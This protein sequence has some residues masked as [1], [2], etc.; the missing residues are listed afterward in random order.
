MFFFVD[1]WGPIQVKKRGGK[2]Y[3]ST[4]H[5]TTIPRKQKPKGTVTLIGALSAT[6]N[7]MA[8]LFEP[9]KDTRSIVNLLE[10]LHNQYQTKS[11][12]YITWDAVSWHSSIALTDWLDEFN[13]ASR[14]ASAGPIIELVPLPTSA[15]FL[16]V[17][18]GVFTGMTKAV[19]HNSDYQSSEEMKSAI[20]RHFRERNAHFN[21]NP[22]RAGKRIWD[23]DFFVEHDSLRSGNYGEW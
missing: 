7:Q 8:W 4:K 3:R 18:E 14:K 1:E 12:L 6:T 5:P 21:D 9:T 15:Q 23:L 20:S 22:R 2:A 13:D 10:I 19:I 11:K 16:N 17:I